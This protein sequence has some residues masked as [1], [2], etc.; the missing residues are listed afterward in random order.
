MY[1]VE[2]YKTEDGQIPFKDWL[3]GLAD[4]QAKARVITRVQ[5]MA[6]GNL[7]DCKPLQ[8]GVWELRIDHG[9]GYRIYYAKAGKKLLLLLIGG[10]KGKQQFDIDK[11][12][13]YWKDWNRR[14]PHE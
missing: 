3:S 5:R 9:P 6:N 2:D 11:A 10:D 7:G 12:I 1:Q 8:D 14:T 4:R 13:G